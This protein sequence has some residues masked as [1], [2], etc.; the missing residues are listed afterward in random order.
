[1]TT[2]SFWILF[3]DIDCPLDHRFSARFGLVRSGR[4]QAYGNRG[5][6]VCIVEHRARARVLLLA[7]A[8]SL[9][10]KLTQSWR[11][12]LVRKTN[13][14]GARTTVSVSGRVVVVPIIFSLLVT[15]M[16]LLVFLIV[17]LSSIMSN[18]FIVPALSPNI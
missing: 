2:G 9:T 1:M 8:R 10:L 5:S 13:K 16:L 18:R 6:F 14:N 15:F 4:R 11:A 17:A 12:T 3:I 7:A